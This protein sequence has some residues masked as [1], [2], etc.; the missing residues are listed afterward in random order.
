MRKP[1]VV[2]VTHEAAGKIGGIG[3]VL[4]GMFTSKSYQEEVDRTILI[5]PLFN[6][7]G[8]VSTRL[9]PGGEVLY[10]SMD[11]LI[12]SN[13]VAAFRR[14]E[15]TYNVEIVYGRRTFKDP[16][17]GITSRPEILLIDI[18][19]MDPAPLNEFKSALFR[20]YGIRSNMYEHLWEFEQYVRLSPARDCG[21]QGH[22]SRRSRKTNHH[23]LS[24]EFMGMPTAVAGILDPYNFKTVFVC[25]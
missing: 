11:G 13:Y 9:G 16:M 2:H 5:S 20:E 25:S 4:D 1:T 18:S 10:S 15:S 12:R 6:T 23:R 8:D 19:R 21:D 7:Q 24:H 22:R 3:A 17:N 14:I